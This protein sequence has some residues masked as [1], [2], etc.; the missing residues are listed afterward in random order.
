MPAGETRNAQMQDKETNTR[1]TCMQNQVNRA[2]MPAMTCF[3][4][5][6]QAC[7]L[8]TEASP[9]LPALATTQRRCN[10]ACLGRGVQKQQVVLKAII[11]EAS[12]PPSG[13]FALAPRCSSEPLDAN[14]GSRVALMLKVQWR[15]ACRGPV[16][17]TLSAMLTT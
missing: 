17:H 15:L 3:M 6:T 2:T 8:A 16:A 4:H 14:D 7:C 5:A 1:R 9:Y 11:T 10:V 13:R 12:S